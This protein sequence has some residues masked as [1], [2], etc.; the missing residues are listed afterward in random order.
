MKV[1]SLKCN[2]PILFLKSHCDSGSEMHPN[3]NVLV[4]LAQKSRY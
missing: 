1:K 4:L 3:L 2:E